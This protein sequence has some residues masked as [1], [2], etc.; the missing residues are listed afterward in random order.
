MKPDKKEDKVETPVK[1]KTYTGNVVEAF[2][3]K[4]KQYKVGDVYET[5]HEKNFNHLI[6]INKIKDGNNK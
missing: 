3:I 2:S 1:S 4:K 5:T 6:S